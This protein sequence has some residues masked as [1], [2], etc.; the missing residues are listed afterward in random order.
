MDCYILLQTQMLQATDVA[1]SGKQEQDSSNHP[2]GL[3]RAKSEQ[4]R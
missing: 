2:S 4:C 1:L 3:R